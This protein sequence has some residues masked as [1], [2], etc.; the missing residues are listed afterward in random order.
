MRDIE[1]WYFEAKHLDSR[2]NQS[3]GFVWCAVF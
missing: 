1:F 2:C 3:C